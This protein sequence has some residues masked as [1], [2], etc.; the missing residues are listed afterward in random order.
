MSELSLGKNSKFGEIDFSKLKSGITKEDLNI[1]EGSVLASIFDSIDTNEEGE[2]QGKLDRKELNTF[3]AK[4]KDLCGDPDTT[5]SKREAKK[6][7]IN[8]ERLGKNKK[9]L[10]KFL[11]KLSE[12]TIGISEVKTTENSEIIEYEDGRKEEIFSD[13]TKTLTDKNGNITELDKDGNI[14]KT[15]TEKDGSKTITEFKDNKKT[16][17]TIENNGKKEIIT[18]YSGNPIQKT[19]TENNETT[20]YKYEENKWSSTKKTTADG[21]EVTY[22]KD[23]TTTK[24]SEDG[25]SIIEKRGND[26]TLLNKTV[27]YTNNNQLVKEH[28]EYNENGYTQETTVDDV[29]TSQEKKIGENTY[30][31]DY[32]VY[33]SNNSVGVKVI[34][35]NG[36]ALA[37]IAKKFGC[38]V[39]EL[40]KANPSKLKGN[41]P[42]Q[43]FNVG[44]EII[45]PKKLEAD[46]KALQGR[47]SKDEAIK[48]YNE[49]QERIKE[50]QERIVA[51]KQAKA[52]EEAR[53]KAEQEAQA[54]LE[55]QVR[56]NENIQKES[57]KQI[58][59][60]LKA[61]I[62]GLND[63]D[64]IN[65]ILARIDDPIEFEEVN[66]LL[67]DLGY[68]AD[69]LYSSIEKFINQELQR[70]ESDFSCEELET[71]V[72][73]WINDGILTGQA[74]I[75]AQ[76]RLA[77]RII[78]DAGDGFG[79]DC[80]ML[81]K[82]ISMIKDPAGQDSSKAQE[83]YQKV[84]EIIAKHNTFYGIGTKC[85]DLV[86]Y[87]EG[88]VWDHEIKKYKGILAQN[89]ALDSTESADAVNDL[90]VEATS[91][92][93][94]SESYLKQA[95]M[96]IKTPEE[97]KAIEA[98]LKEYCEEHGIEPKYDGQSYLQAILY[99][100]CDTFMGFN[101]NHEEIRKFNEMLIAQ[102]AYTEEEAVKIRAEQAALQIF[103][104]DFTNIYDA[105]SQI[106][107]KAVYDQLFSQYGDRIEKS[108]S[109]LPTD[110]KRNF[111]LA[112]FASNNFLASN[113]AA[114]VAFNLIQSSDFDTRAQGLKAIRN[115]EVANIVDEKLKNTGSSLEKV[116]AE[117]NKEKEIYKSKAKLWDG[118]AFIS[119]IADHIS[120]EYRK[121]TDMSDNIYIESNNQTEISQENKANYDTAIQIFEDKLEEM[122]KAYQEALEDQGVVSDAVNLFC[123]RYNI[124]TTRDEIEARIEHDTETL[125]LLKLAAEGK[126]SKI[127]NGNTVSVSFEEVF[128]ERQSQKISSSGVVIEGNDITFD[129]EK[130]TKVS[131]QAE[132]MRAMELAK[133]NILV[134]FQDLNAGIEASDLKI[135][136]I[137]ICNTLEILSKI[138]GNSMILESMGYSL[139]DG[140]IFD[141][142]NKKVNVENLKLLANSLKKELIKLA[143]EILG[144]EVSD[145]ASFRDLEKTLNKAYDKQI[146]GF[147]KEFEEA[148]GQVPND[149]MIEKYIKTINTG[150]NI[151]NIGA[152][153]G[154]TILTAGQGT[155]AMFAAV[156]GTSFGLNALEK[157]TDADGYTM[158]EFT[159]DAEQAIWDGALTVA[160]YKI[161]S[162]AEQFAKGSLNIAFATKLLTKN[163]N[164]LSKFIKSPN[165]LEKAAVWVARVEAAGFEISSD[166]LQSLVQMYCQEGKFDEQA[167]VNGLIMSAVG[168]V[169]GHAMGAIDDVKP[170]S[171]NDIDSSRL[172]AN[173]RR[174]Y[175]ESLE[176]TPTPK[177]VD[178]YLDEVGYKAP[179]PEEQA[180]IDRINAEAEAAHAEAHKV[181]NNAKIEEAKSPKDAK[182]E[183]DKLNEEIK[184][185]DNQIKD[186]EKRIENAKKWGKNDT[187]QKLQKQVDNLKNLKAEKQV[188][189]DNLKKNIN[190]QEEVKVDAQSSDEPKVDK[191]KADEPKVDEPNNAGKAEAE[192]AKA[193]EPKA[194]DVK[195]GSSKSVLNST[196]IERLRIDAR[197]SKIK[198]LE[199]IYETS[200]ARMNIDGKTVEVTI[201]KGSQ[202]GS[203]PGFWVKDNSTGELYYYKQNSR[204]PIDWNGDIDLDKKEILNTERTQ[205][206]NASEVLAS[207]LYD[208]AGING[209]ELSIVRN[210]NNECIGIMSKFD[211]YTEIE[212]LSSDVL[213]SVR[214]GFAVDCWLANWDALKDGNVL[215]SN[216]NAVRADVGGSLCFRAR[217][218]RKIGFKENV[219][220]LT[221]FF[222]NKSLSKKYVEGMSYDE[223]LNS[224]SHVTGISD[225]QIYDLVD[226]FTGVKTNRNPIDVG[227]V[228][229][230]TYSGGIQ[231]P[232]Y[233]KETLIARRD[234]MARFEANCKANPMKQGET[235][236]DYMIRMAN[237]TPRTEYSLDF[238]TKHMNV[239]ERAQSSEG[240][241]GRGKTTEAGHKLDEHLT[242][243]Q[244]RLLDDSYNA[245]ESSKSKR[246]QF[247]DNTSKLTTDHMVHST[248]EKFLESILSDGLKSR[249]FHGNAIAHNKDGYPGSRTP[250]CADVFDIQQDSDIASYLN[251]RSRQNGEGNFIDKEFPLIVFNK[252]AVDPKIMNNSFMVSQADSSVLHY[253]GNMS[254]Y[255]TYNTHRGVPVGIPAN[256]IEKI[257]LPRGADINKYIQ[258]IKKHDL[259]AK[260]FDTSGNLLFDPSS[261]HRF[262]NFFGL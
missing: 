196:E 21:K 250:M 162:I 120:D 118:L 104:G 102:G 67:A 213:S 50:E 232:Q 164:L 182:S 240:L 187:A 261:K 138:T 137:G 29:A 189:V 83:V 194:D 20:E 191:P 16:K 122:K 169:A 163:K 86:D 214:E 54:K 204:N 88:E 231:N 111:I 179:T 180:D 13:G 71:L 63:F 70:V 23:G 2:S 112:E 206:R 143:A 209:P 200:Q 262:K 97:R 134:A 156:A 73:K 226:K 218:G 91:G 53:I 113:Q 174:L 128:N 9:E 248:N 47:K 136:A 153:I 81:E 90:I 185:F 228:V 8:G 27:S 1:E 55:A 157:S 38:T 32:V 215:I 107:D 121:N 131:K 186:L 125:R 225:R 44:E 235:M 227:D 66:K 161:G 147:K 24:Y 244:K 77:A 203:N 251:T 5:L 115:E 253:D 6:F 154:V 31:I 109:N 151:V 96:A 89:G 11:D 101:H 76:A 255:T 237:I 252:K 42:N 230:Y 254:G 40:I 106:K 126:L 69:D 146:E 103:E 221:S 243:S 130:V 208:L 84:N 64:K 236:A 114:E 36:E 173:E 52:V 93:G 65:Q 82:G 30:K 211:N 145:V 148:F 46:N 18:Y 165:I 132:R 190:N 188:E 56:E 222:S 35:Q 166:T 100:E 234:Y 202:Q 59:N 178:D 75:D 110:E 159:S 258:I 242:P 256:A 233:L 80:D 152:M 199:A 184:G 238:T 61:A 108:I 207:E 201:Y 7:E 220:E 167:F 12:L 245:Y 19:V 33:D 229:G 95:L 34:V 224:L 260:I 139:K 48:E 43:Y 117:F 172:S 22:G 133:D 119:S 205:A 246:H 171:K 150:K 210:S 62:K 176:D 181:E 105:V 68:E 25:K 4:I 15:I 197:N 219:D 14:I 79:T 158:L 170:A 160:G 45:I 241:E 26:D 216:G 41:H 144:A 135:L 198:E 141:S 87:L 10:L 223:L 28:T 123:E 74:A 98:K 195:L 85:K 177:D 142:N 99:A 116:Y 155:L 127:E 51:E 175:E 49:T 140:F 149:E 193:D 124:G 239:S 37:K 259:N 60:E 72:Q 249:E 39:E 257:V 3:I 94:T 217:G 192:N 78:C 92:V 247:N 57:A 183:I 17:E 129:S 168:N 58:V 212:N